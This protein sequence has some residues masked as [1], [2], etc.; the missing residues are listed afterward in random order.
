MVVITV[1]DDG[2]GLAK[3]EFS[4]VTQPFERGRTAPPGNGSG[5]GLAIANAIARFHRGR[6]DLAD[7]APGLRVRVCF[8]A[9]DSVDV[10]SPASRLAA[11]VA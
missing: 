4:R 10:P 2:P 9:N 7:A 5:L 1:C 3:G 8:P 6:L 11:A